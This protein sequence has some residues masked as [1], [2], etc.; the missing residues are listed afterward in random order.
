M[1]KVYSFIFCLISICA[2]AQILP[3]RERAL[4]VDEILGDR[5]NTLLPNLMDRSEIDM[6][7]L[8]SREYN[9]DPVL[10]TMLPAT[11][12]NARRR[13]ILVFY[14]NKKENTIEKLAKVLKIQACD[15]LA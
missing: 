5:L 8:I 11:W 7:I 10:K 15:L 12:F 3:E 9:E 6:W 13:T 2:S 4:V 1:T 14:R